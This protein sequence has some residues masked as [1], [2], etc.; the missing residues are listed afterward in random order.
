MS[1][2]TMPREIEDLIVY[3]AYGCHSRKHFCDE[4]DMFCEFRKSIPPIFLRDRFLP[5]RW[6]RTKTPYNFWPLNPFK[7]GFPYYPLA[8]LDTSFCT[9]STYIQSAFGQIKP[10]AF[11]KMRTYEGHIF[12]K[13]NWWM[14]ETGIGDWN[15]VMLHF[16]DRFQW[17][18]ADLDNYRNPELPWIKCFCKACEG[19]RYVQHSLSPRFSPR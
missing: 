4:I 19:A 1:F 11:R 18:L 13:I 7:S 6:G 3:F 2:R 12:R 9:W 10:C 5:R 16:L 15:A 14:T 8:G 17:D